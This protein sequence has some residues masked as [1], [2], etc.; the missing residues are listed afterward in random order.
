LVVVKIRGVD[1]QRGLLADRFDDAGMGVTQ[2]VD[3]DTCNEVEIAVTVDVV[4]IAAL[5]LVYD[6][7]IAAIVLEQVLAFQIDDG[8]YGEG[9]QGVWGA[10][11]LFMIQRGADSSPAAVLILNFQ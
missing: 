7:W 5:S 9:G 11:H 2:R 8:V 1:E 4:N 10:G 3:A 6:Q